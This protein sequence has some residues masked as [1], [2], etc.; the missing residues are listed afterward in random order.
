MNYPLT[1]T[2]DYAD[3]DYKHKS[4]QT[5][6]CGALRFRFRRFLYSIQSILK[7]TITKPNSNSRFSIFPRSF[8]FFFLLLLNSITGEQFS[9]IENKKKI[10][11]LADSLSFRFD[12]RIWNDK[13]FIILFTFCVS[14]LFPLSK[15]RIDESLNLIIKSSIWIKIYAI[16]FI[17]LNILFLVWKSSWKSS[18]FNTPSVTIEFLSVIPHPQFI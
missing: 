7:G 1:I 8:L 5:K 14:R 12:Q 18:P 15:S 2:F 6:C 9:I 11:N 10:E 13:L 16:I 17:H 3:A 4:I